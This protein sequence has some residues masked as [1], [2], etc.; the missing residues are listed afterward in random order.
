MLK[1]I[2]FVAFIGGGYLAWKGGDTA[3]AGDPA[4]YWQTIKVAA[5]FGGVSLL[6]FIALVGVSKGKGK[7]KGKSK[8][9]SS[10]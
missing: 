7:S 10:H 5:G 4:Q 3:A 9:S 1:F 8:A 2:L 6:S